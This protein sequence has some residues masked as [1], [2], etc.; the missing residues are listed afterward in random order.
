MAL[1]QLGILY[2]EL[3][4]PKLALDPLIRSECLHR[5]FAETVGTSPWTPDDLFSLQSY[6]GGDLAGLEAAVQRR[7][8]AFEDAHTHTLYFLA[9]VYARSSC[10]VDIYGLCFL[11]RSVLALVA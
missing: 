8:E 2:S 6:D 3:K 4:G 5:K 11:G 1:N 9:Q 10:V 7:T